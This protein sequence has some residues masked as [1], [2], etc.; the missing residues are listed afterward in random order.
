MNRFSEIC[1]LISEKEKQISSLIEEAID[2]TQKG[3]IEKEDLFKEVELCRFFESA[4]TQISKDWTIFKNEKVQLFAESKFCDICIS[5]DKEVRAFWN[6]KERTIR[7]ERG[8]TLSLNSENFS[9][10]NIFNVESFVR[11]NISGRMK[12][13]SNKIVVKEL[14]NL[15]LFS[16]IRK[17]DLDFYDFQ[18]FGIE[19]RMTLSEFEEIKKKTKMYHIVYVYNNNVDN[20]QYTIQQ[21]KKHLI[22]NF[23]YKEEDF[24]KDLIDTL[25]IQDAV[26]LLSK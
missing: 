14:G 6:W 15:I 3:L 18:R 25:K 16:I 21:T 19:L 10:I 23:D 9:K 12:V 4:R 17:I 7:D 11:K 22:D 8:Q 13:F 5:A 2:L 24:D 1:Q 26:K 20:K